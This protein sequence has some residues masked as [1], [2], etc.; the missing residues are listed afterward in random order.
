MQATVNGNL[1]M[2]NIEA[3]DDVNLSML[4]LDGTLQNQWSNYHGGSV[5]ASEL[6]VRGGNI[7]LG[8]TT[9]HETL[10]NVY[11]GGEA[12]ELLAQNTTF[13]APVTIRL[14]VTNDLRLLGTVINNEASLEGSR[15]GGRL[16]L[17]N[18]QLSGSLSL[19]HLRTTSLLLWNNSW[20]GGPDSLD[21][22]GLVFSHLSFED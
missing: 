17:R 16:M 14:H 19:R 10:S 15:I 22:D 1:W 4:K 21:L 13:N 3:H 5:N 11:F 12:R 8:G 9:F 6:R 7:F 18:I 2:Q 20:N